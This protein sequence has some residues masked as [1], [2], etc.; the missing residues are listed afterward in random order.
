MPST[1]TLAPH[2]PG[3]TG[4][5][6]W[7]SL[8]VLLGLAWVLPDVGAIFWQRMLA[9]YPLSPWESLIVVD[10]TRTVRGE[11]V[12][13]MPDAG[14]ATHMY[15]PL[16]IWADA[17]VFRLAGPNLQTPRLL[18]AFAAVGTAGLLALVVLRRSGPLLAAVTFGLTA[19]NF[20]R[21]REVFTEAR[22]DAPSIFLGTFALVLLY[23]GA[24]RPTGG[25]AGWA[26][27][28]AGSAACVAAFFFKQPAAAAAAVPAL[29]LLIANRRA[30]ALEWL[31][32]ATPLATVAAT[33]AAVFFLWPVGWFYM[34]EVPR[35]YAVSAGRSLAA[36]IGLVQWNTLFLTVF[37]AFVAARVGRRDPVIAWALAALA[38][39]TAASVPA[40]AK[41]G[42]TVNSLLP[43]FLAMGFFCCAIL[44]AVADRL[45]PRP[46]ALRVAAAAVFVLLPISD[47]TT[48]DGGG[49]KAVLRRFNGG[50]EWADVV[51]LVRSLPG[52]TVCP[53]DPTIPLF[54]DGFAGR[55]VQV[56]RDARGLTGP[57]PPG[58]VDEITSA[59]RVVRVSGQRSPISPEMLRRWGFHPV[60][61]PVMR[62]DM[63]ELFERDKAAK[64]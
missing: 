4:R 45:R 12:Y 6:V 32:A 17:A 29:A 44:P 60:P 14:P 31:R 3:R 42:G 48:V 25:R 36:L 20:A 59:D 10:A 47:A 28:A 46:V 52:R 51:G 37:G 38:I 8:P 2:R 34:A 39:L 24:R 30:P 33:L 21:A 15:G 5:A 40:F 9:P 55:T 56:E 58:V 41:Y 11:G 23:A 50:E 19:V 43:S 1:E 53:D 35:Q 18:S 16:V 61:T 7:L 63:Y 54:A 22:P 13:A 64:R 27:T 57:L 26:L 49:M 62:S